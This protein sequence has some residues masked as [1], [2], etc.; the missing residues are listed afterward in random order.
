MSAHGQVGSETCGQ[1]A[2]TSPWILHN[3]SVFLPSRFPFFNLNCYQCTKFLRCIMLCFFISF[4]T[5]RARTLNTNKLFVVA[6]LTM[7]TVSLALQE[8]KHCQLNYTGRDSSVDIAIRFGLGIESRWRRG[9][10]QPFWP[11]QEPTQLPVQWF[12]CHT[13]IHRYIH[14]YNHTYIPAFIYACMHTY[15]CKYIHACINV[16]IHTYIHTYLHTYTYI[17][18]YIRAYI[19]NAFRDVTHVCNV[20]LEGLEILEI[21]TVL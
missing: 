17:H 21:L 16:Y 1:W 19:Y 10:P 9:F 15:I 13:C 14:T 11:A 18:T 3:I 2:A 20:L 6:Y 8:F 7:L 12:P 5:Y 4:A